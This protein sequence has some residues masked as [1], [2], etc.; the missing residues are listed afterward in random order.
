MARL[1]TSDG[2]SVG[3]NQRS[4]DGRQALDS[5]DILVVANA[6]GWWLPRGAR[7]ARSAFTADEIGAVRRW[8]EQGGALLLVADHYPAGPAAAGLARVFGVQMNGGW[9]L[10]STR[11]APAVGNPSWVVYD[12]THGGLGAHPI[13]E[14]R[15]SVE[16]IQQVIAFTGQ[17]LSVPAG[18]VALLQCGPAAFDVSPT[19]AEHSARGMAQAVALPVGKGRVVITGEAAM[20]TAQVTGGGRFRFGRSWP[21]TNDRQFTLNIFH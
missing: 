21:G 7:A 10:D 8:V 4:F 16:R 18:A 2:Y 12:R 20:L 19:G 17:S 9:L 6:L 1:L 13:L 14:G 11:Q 3:A 15:D 5:I